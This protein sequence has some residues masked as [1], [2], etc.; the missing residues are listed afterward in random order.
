MFHIYADGQSIYQPLDDNMLILSPKLT[1]EMGKAGYLEFSIP[2]NN[3]YYD[4]LRQ[5]RSII[6]VDYDDVEIFR[7]R[8]LS[9]ER[10]FVNIKKVYCEGD[11][12]YLVDSVQKGEKYEGTTHDLFRKIIAAH[13]ARM[14]SVKQFTV[15]EI[16]IENRS[17]VLAGQSDDID[18]LETNNFDY[19]QIALNSMTDNWKTSYDY[20]ESCLIDYC[21]GYLRTRRVGNTTYIDLVENYGSTSTQEIEFGVN[22][23]DLTEE[24]RAEEIF[25]VLIPLGDDNLTIASV[26]NG[27]DELVDEEAV[28]TYGRIVKTH[29]FDN[30][31]K[32][33]T[34][35]ENGRRFLENHIN[36]PITIVV[37][38]VDLHMV[39]PDVE[40]IYV[41][42]VVRLK[43]APHYLLRELTCTKIEYDLENP[44]NNLYTFGI[45]RQSLTERY[46]KD[47]N[48]QADQTSDKVLSSVGGSGGSDGSGGSGGS[49]GSG[50]KNG[51][52]VG[53]ALEQKAQ[54]MLDK[55]YDAWINCDPESA[56]I[57]LGAVYRELQNTRTVLENQVGIELDAVA[58]NINIKDLKTKYDELG[59]TI[60]QQNI[61]INMLSSDTDARLQLLVSR[62]NALSETEAAHYAEILLIANDLESAIEMKADRINMEAMQ[63][64]LKAVSETITETRNV[65]TNQVGIDLDGKNGN[66]NIR[67]LNTNVDAIGNLVSQH[68]AT[69]TTLANN[70]E[71]SIK[72]VAERVTA[73]E[74]K[75]ASLEIRINETESEID[76]KADKVTL[77]SNLTTINSKITTINSEITNVKKLIADEINALKMDTTWLQSKFISGVDTIK[78]DYIWAVKQLLVGG[79]TVATQ[80][81]VKDLLSKYAP[82]DHTHGWGSIENKPTRFLPA[83]H[84]HAFSG[85]M[86]LAWGHTHT[87]NG[88]G[89]V[90]NYTNKNIEISGN[91]KSN[92]V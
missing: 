40:E 54:E 11:L 49:S 13:N 66:V 55:F 42:D 74:T 82:A 89:G 19:R 78:A 68:S 64:N 28:A 79:L 2:P 52:G 85:S 34:L 9:V 41:G 38:A 24:A 14:E 92:T 53:Q 39:N 15:G 16:G 32:A 62:T 20:I 23:L 6:T 76:L 37:K 21:G 70:T 12:A 35:L 80:S 25:T 44:D 18:D 81:W 51:G 22:M 1:L 57:D 56:H 67:S 59:N 47:K 72:A 31:Y 87:Q 83:S 46:R 84:Y 65:L 50:S 90:S 36:V 45:P 58:G 88:A 3:R 17:V 61:E 63:I 29:V 8:V 48:E 77:N 43:S 26:N 60:L 86:S 33:S 27:S 30:V 73:E 71:S 75:I 5:L 7:G 91:T 4:Q 69:I 10:N